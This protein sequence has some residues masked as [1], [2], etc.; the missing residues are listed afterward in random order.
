MRSNFIPTVV[1]FWRGHLSVSREEGLRVFS[2]PCAYEIDSIPIV[3]SRL[4]P[5]SDVLHAPQEVTSSQHAIV[6]SR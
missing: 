6:L 1:C 5:F 2:H 4:L 3:L